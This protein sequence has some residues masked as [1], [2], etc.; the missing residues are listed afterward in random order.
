[1]LVVAKCLRFLQP[2]PCS[3]FLLSPLAVIAVACSVLASECSAVWLCARWARSGICFYASGAL[4]M[5]C[6][7]RGFR[8]WLSK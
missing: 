3:L 7:P 1:M 8:K 6:V 5:R 4:G 2:V